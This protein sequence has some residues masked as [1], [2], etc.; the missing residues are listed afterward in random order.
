[1]VVSHPD[2]WFPA[3][4]QLL[5]E[6]ATAVM[7]SLVTFMRADKA[8]D[9]DPLSLACHEVAVLM[10]R[11]ALTGDHVCVVAAVRCT[12]CTSVLTQCAT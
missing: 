11:L 3:N 9:E 4:L 6:C 12:L 5:Q 1:M 10:F 7:D 8:E 2:A